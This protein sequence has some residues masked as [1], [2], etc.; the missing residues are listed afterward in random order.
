[1]R[2]LR[3]LAAETIGVYLDFRTQEVGIAAALSE[4]QAL[5][6]AYRVGDVYHAL[7]VVCG[8]T[9]DPDP[10][11]WKMNNQEMRN[12]MKRLQLAINYG[13]GVPSLAKGLDR[14][15]LIASGIIERHRRAYPRYWEW[16]EDT[17]NTATIRREMRA[18]FG[19]P[20]R[21]S[22][23]PNRPTLYNFPMQSNE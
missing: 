1:M 14:H 7:A 11:H 15:P 23:K 9:D 17:V 19:W 16:R 4:D 2:L 3:V 22:T 5:M 21:I 18:V 6:D 12:R 8:F 13:M 20:L 10:V